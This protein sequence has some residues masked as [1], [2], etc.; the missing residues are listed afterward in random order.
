MI[1]SRRINK[2]LLMIA[3][4]ML[5]CSPPVFSL[6]MEE[7]LEFIDVDSE[8]VG[9]YRMTPIMKQT[10]DR[11][12]CCFDGRL[13]YSQLEVLSPVAFPI[14]E[15]VFR[16]LMQPRFG[17]G[18]DRRHFLNKGYE[19]INASMSPEEIREKL[20]TLKIPEQYE[21][22]KVTTE[23]LEQL[24]AENEEQFGEYLIEKEAQAIKYNQT[25]SEKVVKARRSGINVE[26][27]HHVQITSKPYHV[28]VGLDKNKSM[29]TV[30]M[31]DAREVFGVAGTIITLKRHDDN[32][33]FGIGHGLAMGIFNWG[34]GAITELEF[35]L[36]LDMESK[37]G[38][39]GLVTKMMPV[40]GDTNHY[41][42]GFDDVD[43]VLAAKQ[44]LLQHA[45]NVQAGGKL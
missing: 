19:T 16:E 29:L 14:V 21:V 13:L 2:L 11:L 10:K 15:K 5:F 40:G 17:E 6:E 28:G 12:V 26:V 45:T 22:D 7:P 25:H 36:L 9:N 3:L 23:K 31:I 43:A 35:Q 39:S 32:Y 24:R 37:L 33:A 44:W 18:D 1:Q 4:I 42:V 27:F 41:Y 38:V 20:F 34:G 30:Q 8:R